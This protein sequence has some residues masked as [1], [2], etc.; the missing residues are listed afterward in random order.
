MGLRVPV[1]RVDYG[2]AAFSPDFTAAMWCKH[3][4]QDVRGIRSS[5]GI[6]AR[7]PRCRATLVAEAMLDRAAALAGASAHGL[8]LIAPPPSWIGEYQ[9]FEDWQV[10]QSMR[11][12]QARVASLEHAER[13]SHPKAAEPRTTR[14]IEGAHASMAAPHVKQISRK[15]PPPLGTRALLALGLVAVAGGAALVTWSFMTD[16]LEWWNLGVPLVVVGHLSLFVGLVFQLERVWQNSREAV[17]KLD[18]VNSRLQ[19]MQRA[20]ADGRALTDHR[21]RTGL[22]LSGLGLLLDAGAAR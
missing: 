3:C 1:S 6:A 4:R 18:N 15:S 12:V 19:R 17:R 21:S 8:D 20:G 11:H 14:R 9:S 7:C 13:P 16:R 22:G 5:D 10:D 2:H